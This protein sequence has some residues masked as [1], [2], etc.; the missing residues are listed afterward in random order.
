MRYIRFLLVVFLSFEGFSNSRSHELK[1]EC[2]Q[3]KE[4]VCDS[5]ECNVAFELCSLSNKNVV[6]GR[7][8]ID[9]FQT[10]YRMKNLNNES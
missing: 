2:L 5:H 10:S 8:I 4:S 6:R 9:D 7:G 1:Q 3:K